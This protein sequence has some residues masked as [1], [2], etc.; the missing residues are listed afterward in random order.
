M[1]DTARIPVLKQSIRE[2]LDTLPSTTVL[3]TC[4]GQQSLF[5]VQPDWC[6]LVGPDD[7]DPCEWLNVALPGRWNAAEFETFGRLLVTH[8]LL[9]HATIPA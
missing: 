8:Y 2:V 5:R 1:L 3:L 4:H 6:V 9:Q 7:D